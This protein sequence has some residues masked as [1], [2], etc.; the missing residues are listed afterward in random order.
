MR[1]IRTIFLVSVA[2]GLGVFTLGAPAGAAPADHPVPSAED[3]VSPEAVQIDPHV[4][5]PGDLVAP[6][7]PGDEGE[8]GPPEIG[9]DGEVDEVPPPELEDPSAEPPAVPC[10]PGYYYDEQSASWIWVG[11]DALPEDCDP[12]ESTPQDCDGPGYTP[13]EC[14]QPSDQPSDEPE[15]ETEG[16]SLPFTGGATLPLAIGGLVTTG[17]GVALWLASRRR[18]VA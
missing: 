4:Q 10:E 16:G 11:P 9:D 15:T 13:E 14:D 8:D 6:A 5:L 1:A 17:S 3:L 12:P 7:D 18:S 2:A